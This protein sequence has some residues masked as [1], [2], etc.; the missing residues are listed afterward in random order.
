MLDRMRAGLRAVGSDRA[1]ATAIEY[2][3]VAVFIGI[4]LIAS[5]MSIGTSVSSFF[6]EVATGL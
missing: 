4:V 1:G 5:M 3:M 6:M 2:A